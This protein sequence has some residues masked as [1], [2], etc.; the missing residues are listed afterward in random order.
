MKLSCLPVS[1]FRDIIEDRMSVA[2]WAQIGASVG[3]DAIDLSIMLVKDLSRAGVVRLRAEIE[4][5]GM[6]ITMVTSY[7]DFTHPDPVCRER[8]LYLALNTLQVAESLNARY[9]RVTAGQAHP[10]TSR[11]DG[12]AWA[13]EGLSRL[14]ELSQGCRVEF[15]IENHSKP[16]AWNYT[17]FS[18]PPDVFLD[19]VRQT[20]GL[21]LGVNFD[22]ANATAF[23]ENPSSLLAKLID[24]VVTVHA[25]DSAVRGKLIMTLLGT[26]IVPFNV[27][28][29]QLKRS[30]FDGWICIEE[31]SLMGWEGVEAAARFVRQKWNEA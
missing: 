15:V 8:E 5:T 18:Q 4:A 25:A 21:K 29:T 2:E 23:A 10:Q 17:D 28:F 31:G 20:A 19:I 6:S 14:L 9:L 30:G 12:T 16:M 22:T 7:Q 13:I 3:L 24:R 27:L 26:G 11:E 1:F